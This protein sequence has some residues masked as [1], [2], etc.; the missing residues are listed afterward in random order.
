MHARVQRAEPPESPIRLSRPFPGHQSCKVGGDHD[1][2]SALRDPKYNELCGAAFC[3]FAIDLFLNLQP[4]SRHDP[5][6]DQIVKCRRRL[7]LWNAVFNVLCA[8]IRSHHLKFRGEQRVNLADVARPQSIEKS[9]Q[10]LSRLP[11]QIWLLGLLGPSV[12]TVQKQC[13]EHK[14]HFESH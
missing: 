5:G 8:A 2:L 9:R 13:G 10:R 4:H 7:D 3:Q 6:N 14:R 11:D 1:F 12:R